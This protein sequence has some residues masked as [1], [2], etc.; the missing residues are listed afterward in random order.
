MTTLGMWM[1]LVKNSGRNTS[2]VIT[3]WYAPKRR[4]GRIGFCK[5]LLSSQNEG[6][7]YKGPEHRHTGVTE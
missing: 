2:L 6:T 5:V 3:I 4:G 7:D 1:N